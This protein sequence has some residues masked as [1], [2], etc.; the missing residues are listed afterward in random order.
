[1]KCSYKA[2]LSDPRSPWWDNVET[3]DVVETR[4]QIVMDSFKKAIRFL[5]NRFPSR[6]NWKWANMHTL[7]HKH[8][9]G[10]VK[11]LNKIFN[12]G[13][14]AVPGGMETINNMS[15]HMRTDSTFEV[16]FGPAMRTIVDL[17]NPQHALSILPTGQSGHVMSRHY[18]DQ[19]ILH[20]NG[21]YRPMLTNKAQIEKLSKGVLLLVPN[22][23]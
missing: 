19:A 10:Q 6:R 13:P 12:I 4:E 9:L 23:K 8:A 14:Y 16:A 17:G 21:L 18:N 20:A 15:F 1:M 7:E 2:L 5:S 3:K 22:V 11:P